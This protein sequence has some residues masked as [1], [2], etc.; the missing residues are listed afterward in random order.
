MVYDPLEPT[1]ALLS[2]TS[3]LTPLFYGCVSI[4]QFARTK[5][6][7]KATRQTPETENYSIKIVEHLGDVGVIRVWLAR[8][9]SHL[10][11]SPLFFSLI[12]HECGSMIFFI[13]SIV[14]FIWRS[15][16]TTGPFTPSPPT[17]TQPP[18]LGYSSQPFSSWALFIS[19]R[20]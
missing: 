18:V 19:V 17:P 11:L 16:S 5:R 14:S 12:A 3:A 1:K 7:C 13:I 4:I 10:S 9:V 6:V 2:P 8:C 15:G 20:S